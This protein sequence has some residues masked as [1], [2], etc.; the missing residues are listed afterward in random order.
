V[1]EVAGSLRPAAQRERR[2]AVT[3]SV[4]PDL[5]PALADRRRVVQVLANL[6]RNALHHTPEGGLVALRAERQDGWAALV[7]ED[8]GV[9]IPSERLP[10]VF[11]RFYRGDEA[12]DRAGGGAGLGLAIVRELVEAMGGEVGVESA[13][14]QGNALAAVLAGGPESQLDAYAAARRPVAREVVR[15]ARGL[16]RLATVPAPVRPLRNVAL[17]ALSRLPAFRRRL[18]WQLSGLVYR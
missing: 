18:A 1:E 12:R 5:P 9:G 11:E 8:T 4:T 2:V 17:R 13:V 7:V 14:G 6:A 15:F 3:T 16:T 10:H